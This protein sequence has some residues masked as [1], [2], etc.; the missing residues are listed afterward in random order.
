MGGVSR[1]SLGKREEDL[2]IKKILVYNSETR[3]G[4][5]GSLEGRR[6]FFLRFKEPYFNCA[7]VQLRVSKFV[8]EKGVNT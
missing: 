3:R 4:I 8:T 1:E 5:L 6:M 7:K 2:P